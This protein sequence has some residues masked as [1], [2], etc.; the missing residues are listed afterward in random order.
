MAVNRFEGLVKDQS[1]QLVAQFRMADEN[2]ARYSEGTAPDP[3]YTKGWAE[4]NQDIPK[5]Q[6]RPGQE[7]SVAELKRAGRALGAKLFN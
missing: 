1:G 4:I 7:D 5:L 2:L 6:S 3:V